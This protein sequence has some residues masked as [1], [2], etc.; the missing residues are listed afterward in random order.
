MSNTYRILRQIKNILNLPVLSTH[1]PICQNPWF[2]PG[3]MDPTWSDKGLTTVKDL[4]INNH[5]V[6]FSE[7]Q[8]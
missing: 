1:T 4:Y 7:L 8:E 5:F 3:M 2:K 6:S